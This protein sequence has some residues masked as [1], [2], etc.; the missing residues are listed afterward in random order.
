MNLKTWKHLYVISSLANRCMGESNYFSVSHKA[1]CIYKLLL[2]LKKRW[3]VLRKKRFSP[4]D[5]RVR[6][7]NKL[8]SCINRCLLK[9][10]T[11]IW[12]NFVPLFIPKA[13][14]CKGCKVKHISCGTVYKV[15][16][17]A[18]QMIFFFL[19]D[20]WCQT[21]LFGFM[22]DGD[23]WRHWAASRWGNGISK[24]E[25]WFLTWLT[26]VLRDVPCHVC[27]MHF[28]NAVEA[29]VGPLTDLF[30]CASVITSVIW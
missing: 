17:P 9:V 5:A 28:Q 27:S 18:G 29:A 30:T 8:A 1:V 3:D 19:L 13:Q 11:D 24:C 21:V 6:N 23:Q 2:G 4:D 15:F 7:C 16:W 12:C 10:W 26:C 22:A 25:T 20:I 14:E